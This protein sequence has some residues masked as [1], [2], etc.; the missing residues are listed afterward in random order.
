MVRCGHCQAVGSAATR[1]LLDGGPWSLRAQLR[2]L[3]EVARCEQTLCF[4]DVA[5]ALGAG[6]LGGTPWLRRLRR[7]YREGWRTPLHGVVELTRVTVEVCASR[8]GSQRYVLALAVQTD[9]LDTGRLRVQRL[10]EVDGLQLASFVER[11]VA[12]GT[13]VRTSMW[14]GYG[15]LA[16]RGHVHHHASRD[17]VR[18]GNVE[19][20]AN[21]LRVWA[22][23]LDALD[24]ERFD[25]QLEDFAFRY[26]FRLRHAADDH[27]AC[28]DRLVDLAIL[29]PPQ[30]RSRISA[31]G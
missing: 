30:R 5:S 29:D 22:W 28:F 23:S 21:I 18:L 27:G 1:T 14:R 24:V 25:L 10:P 16:R 31:A 4:R 3:F 15:R 20:L 13:T 6:P 2:A 17:E 7:I 26:G 8:R 19:Q 9:G 11:A 12:E